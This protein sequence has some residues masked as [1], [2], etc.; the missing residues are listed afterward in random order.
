MDGDQFLGEHR[1]RTGVRL[2]VREARLGLAACLGDGVR[3][4]TSAG[5]DYDNTALADQGGGLLAGQQQRPVRCALR[6]IE[7]L[8]VD[9]AAARIDGHGKWI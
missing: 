4:C 2:E 1:Q 3:H 6:L 9:H 5:T 7:K 8:Q